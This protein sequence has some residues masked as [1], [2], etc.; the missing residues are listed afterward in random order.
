ML[1]LFDKSAVPILSYGCEVWVFENIDIIERIHLK[2]CKII[3][4][5]KKSTANDMVY[6]ELGRYPLRVL[7]Y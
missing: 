5:V 3:V 1:E 7:I 2:F 4:I 6:G